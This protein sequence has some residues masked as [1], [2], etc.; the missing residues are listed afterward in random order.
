MQ[1]AVMS[2]ATTRKLSAVGTIVSG[3]EGEAS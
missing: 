3:T 1:V 2:G